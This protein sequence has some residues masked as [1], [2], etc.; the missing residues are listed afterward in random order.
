MAFS[1]TLMVWHVIVYIFRL[2]VLNATQGVLLIGK[3]M[4]NAQCQQT[5]A[6]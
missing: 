5:N 4:L 1:T 2:A 3:L 6:S